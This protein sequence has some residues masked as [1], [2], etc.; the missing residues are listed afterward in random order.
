M[1]GAKYVGVV[2]NDQRRMLFPFPCAG[3]SLE[4]PKP[5]QRRENAREAYERT[6]MRRSIV[7]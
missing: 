5:L 6:P 4:A 3:N 7:A 2:F 1:I